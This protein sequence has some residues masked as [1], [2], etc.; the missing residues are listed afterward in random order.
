[1]SKHNH[2]AKDLD[3]AFKAARQ[4]YV[5]AWD[6]LQA[7]KDAKRMAEGSDMERQRAELKCQEAELSFK[8]AEARIWPEFNRRRAE[9]RAALE[10]EVHSGTLASPDAVDPNGLELLKSGILS[11]DDYYSLVDKYDDNPTM[12][13]LVAR[14]ARE[15]ADDMEA[16]DR[17]ALYQLAQEC[18]NGQGQTLRAWDSLSHIADYCSGQAIEGRRD[19]PDHIVSMGKWWKQLSSETVENF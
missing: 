5:E 13:R 17:G 1:M 16:K 8:E 11:A 14:Y 4:E 18:E 9:L 10:H 12:L 2:F 3:A 19:A 7:A 6:K 15:A